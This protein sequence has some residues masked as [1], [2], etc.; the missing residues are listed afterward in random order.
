MMDTAGV[1]IATFEESSGWVRQRPQPGGS[2]SAML[3]NI[4][5]EIVAPESIAEYERLQPALQAHRAR[6]GALP[7]RPPRARPALAADAGRAGDARLGQAH[8]LGRHARR[9]RAAHQPAAQRAAAA[10]D[11]DDPREHDRRHRLPARRRAGALQPALRDD[12]APAAERGRRLEPGRAARRPSAGRGDRGRDPRGADRRCRLRDRVRVHRLRRA[13]ARRHADRRS[14]RHARWS[15]PGCA[16]MRS[17]CA[18]PAA[19]TAST[20]RS[21]CSPT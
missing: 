9:H 3:Q 5:R 13:R 14:A 8:R 4:N 10:R 21:P 19:R 16:G 18:A 1:G 7:R 2:S 17:R 6:R 12:A 20:R 15:R 11:D